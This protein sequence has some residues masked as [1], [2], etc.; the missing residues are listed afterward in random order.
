YTITP[1][2]AT[3]CTKRYD[4]AA[5]EL[6]LTAACPV[7]TAPFSTPPRHL[8]AYLGSINHLYEDGL[9]LLISTTAQL[10]EITGVDLTLRMIAPKADVARMLDDSG[11]VPS[12]IV[13]GFESEQAGLNATLADCR[14]CFLPYSF[15][16]TARVMSGS[17][18]PSKLLDYLAWARQILVFAPADSLPYNL[19]IR[20]HLDVVTDDEVVFKRFLVDLADTS[21]NNSATYRAALYR[22]H[23]PGRASA[24]LIA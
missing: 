19:F 7:D 2:L 17:S 8:A 16:E 9:R 4:I 5:V 15:D 13:C 6:P 20:E 18:F 11:E 23:G 3:L 10:R 14:C 22:R 21:V 24:V 12:W 1:E